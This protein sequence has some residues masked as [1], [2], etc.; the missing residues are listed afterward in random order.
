[1]VLPSDRRATDKYTRIKDLK[2]ISFANTD[3]LKHTSVV[4]QHIIIEIATGTYH[5]FY[6]VHALYPIITHRYNTLLNVA[7]IKFETQKT[8]LP[9]E[10]KWVF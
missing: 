8:L 9:V 6:P 2:V 7:D 1:M 5:N 4:I 10:I 3:K